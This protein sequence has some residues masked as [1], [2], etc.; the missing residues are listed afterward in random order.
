VAKNKKVTKKVTMPTFTK[1]QYDRIA[2]A[3]N[4][5]W[6]TIGGDVITAMQ[7]GE[8]RDYVTKDEFI[9]CVTDA[10]Y[11][12]SYAHD[13]EACKWVDELYKADYDGAFKQLRKLFKFERYG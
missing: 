2:R 13:P 7:E 1:E 4:A 11:M 10:N 6:Q 3:M 12:D 9:E 8:N 5:T